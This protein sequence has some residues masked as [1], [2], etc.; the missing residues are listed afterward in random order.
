M[1]FK[2]YKSLAICI[3]IGLPGTGSFGQEGKLKTIY[4]D[5]QAPGRSPQLFAPGK[6][7]DALSNRDFTISPSGDE[8]FYTIQQRDFLSSTIIHLKKNKGAWG[9]AEVAPF[10]ENSM[11][12]KP[13]SRVMGRSYSFHP[14]GL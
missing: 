14:T 9:K 8:I 1:N 7:S 6:I 3:I 11:T 12:W 2:P 10:P 5:Q 4:F 13:L